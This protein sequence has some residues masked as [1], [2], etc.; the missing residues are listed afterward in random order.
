[1]ELDIWFCVSRTFLYWFSRMHV[2]VI[3]LYKKDIKEGNF[4]NYIGN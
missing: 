2:G 3:F 1:M 4:N